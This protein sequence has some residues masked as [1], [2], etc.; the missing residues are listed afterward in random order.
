MEE[1]KTIFDYLGQLF[2]LY[3]IM[4]VML[5]ILCVLVGD[6]AKEISSMFSLGRK[7]LSVET[8]AEYFLVAV[9]TTI[10][11]YLFFTDVFFHSLSVLA[12]TVFMVLSVVA[13]SS[14]MIVVCDW[15]PTDKLLPWLCY[16]ICFAVSF[17]VSMWVLYLKERMQNRKMEEALNR[18]KQREKEN[19]SRSDN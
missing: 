10:T 2:L 5:N 11:R 9:F 19:G 3:G 18:L 4:I 1:R 17:L 6:E 13:F 16:G 7:G 15:F 8:M 12:R 14:V